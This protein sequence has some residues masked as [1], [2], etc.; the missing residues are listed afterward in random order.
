MIETLNIF[1]EEY[2]MNF[3]VLSGGRVGVTFNSGSL[4]FIHRY[5]NTDEVQ[6]DPYRISHL[7]GYN[8]EF[9]VE[10]TPQLEYMLGLKNG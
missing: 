9:F 2:D 4:R 7:G 6:I 1:V 5:N 10:L 3:M 8:Q